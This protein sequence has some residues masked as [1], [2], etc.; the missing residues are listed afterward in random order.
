[1]DLLE[2]YDRGNIPQN[3][4]IFK[5]FLVTNKKMLDYKNI[6]VSVSGG[7]DSDIMLDLTY[8]L[9]HSNV[10]YVFFDTGLE[11]KATKEHL[12]YIE[13][14]Y[15]VE[16]EVIKSIKPIPI[17]CRNYGQP[18]LSKQI[19]EYIERLQRHNFKWEDKPLD[20][21][22]LEYPNCKV[23]VRWWCN[24]WGKGSK[25]NI[26]YN[27][28]LKEFMIENPPTF[29][30]SNKCCKYAKKDP[31]HKFIKNNDF[32]LNCYGVRKSEGGVRSTAY[33]N[34]F[35][36][37]SADNKIDEFRPIFWYRDETKRAYEKHFNV[38]HS[39]CYTEYG[40]KRTGCA[41]CP[42]NKKFEEELKIIEDHEPNLYKAVNN[43]FKDSYG[44]TRKYIKFKENFNK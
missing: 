15:G 23:A 40:L 29:K 9:S 19:S 30:I 20:E 39:R 35:T 17:T 44:Y 18:F 22:L 16:I 12:K 8:R 31:V 11:Y 26:N 32:D 42:Y 5:S 7:S 27:K 2:E 24:D 4:E 13:E 33:K 1:M 36:N 21:L 34:C 43:I 41:G 10:R 3:E 37:N 14:K 28:G 25:F 38:T 6:V